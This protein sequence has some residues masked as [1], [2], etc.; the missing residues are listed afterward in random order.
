MGKCQT[1]RDLQQGPD[2]LDLVLR[3]APIILYVLDPQ[4][5]FIFTGGNG[6]AAAGLTTG[7]VVGGSAL[8]LYGDAPGAGKAIRG[9]LAGKQTVFEA[10]FE[11]AHFISRLTP[12]LDGAGAVTEVVGVSVDVPGE[13]WTQAVLRREHTRADRAEAERQDIKDYAQV[14]VDTSSALVVMLDPHGKV[15]AV[16]AAAEAMTGYTSEELAGR[17]WF[18]VVMPK[19]RF[20]DLEAVLG[21]EIVLDQRSEFEHPILTKSGRER[22]LVWRSGPVHE[23]GK[24]EGRVFFGV[25]ITERRQVE[26]EIRRL[27]A[28]LERRVHERTA[29]LTAAN[30]DLEAFA[31]SV[32]H[33]LRAP[34]RAVD[35]FSH[36]L[37]T[38][39]AAGLDDEA[40]HYV[41]MIRTSSQAMGRLID[42]L[43]ALSRMGQQP[44]KSKTFD[45]SELAYGAYQNLA[46]AREGRR[47]EWEVKA[48]PEAYGDPALIREVL[49]NLLSNALKFSAPRDVASIEAG[50]ENRGKENLYYVRDNGVGFDMAYKQKLFG[51]FQR[52][53]ASRDFEGTGVGLAIVRRIVTRHGGQVWAESKVDEGATFYFTLPVAKGESS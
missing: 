6:I 12:V 5:R 43:L 4:G 31:Y 10:H 16:N 37:E 20:P 11:G 15:K 22:Y 41:D 18:E 27:N 51:V 3:T 50:G 7:H 33:D 52:L 29:E 28:E 46:P 47:V 23:H 21:H 8:K 39:H 30:Q 53:H 32:S 14:L 38:K 48:M 1:D 13:A 25:D 26:E 9:A 24:L 40:A 17:H 19:D 2:R 35:G 36:L 44:L 45:M 49:A 34:L 42:D